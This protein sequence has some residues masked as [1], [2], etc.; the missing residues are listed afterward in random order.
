[1][2]AAATPPADYFGWGSAAVHP[3]GVLYQGEYETPSDGTAV[4]VRAHARALAATGIPVLLESFSGMVVNAD[5]VPEHVTAVGCPPEVKAEVG[6]LRETSISTHGVV[7]R[8]MVIRSATSLENALVPRYVYV[9]GT[10]NPALSRSLRDS[11]LRVTVAYTVWE[12]DRISKDVAQL[13]DRCGQAWVPC[14]QNADML[15][16]SGVRAAKVHVVPHPYDP[17][18]SLSLLT[19]RIPKSIRHFY[20]IGRWS[21]RKAL[22]ELLGAF[23]EAFKPGD[24]VRLTLKTSPGV[25]IGYPKTP[26]ESLAHWCRQYPIW[27]TAALRSHL[28][29][30]QRRLPRGGILRLHYDGNIYVSPG[31]GEAWNL[32]AYD[33]KIAGNRLLHV[34]YGG[35]ADFAAPDDVAIPYRMEAVG[36]G[37][38]WEP[39]ARWASYDFAALVEALRATTAPTEFRRPDRF[40]ERFSMSAVGTQMADLID[41]L[42]EGVNPTAQTYFRE[43]RQA[44]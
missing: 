34:P 21:R 37:Y 39:G 7:I 24:P 43:R 29:I 11:L 2:S 20:A 10:Q 15:I 8:H 18:D 1:M 17:S 44:R 4:A 26:E 31:H 36:G 40:E 42:I 16:S 19:Q 33:A 35:T 14:R 5:G 25:D 23:L 28:V 41:G 13:L 32:G 30:E 9:H 6:P 12:R 22:H 27:T 3:W 38:G